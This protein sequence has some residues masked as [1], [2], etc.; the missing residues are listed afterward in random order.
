MSLSKLLQQSRLLL[1]TRTRA[2][3]GMLRAAFE[4]W[5]C[6]MMNDND[7]GHRPAAA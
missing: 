3:D 4:N 1:L 6:S 5:Y 7:R 2:L